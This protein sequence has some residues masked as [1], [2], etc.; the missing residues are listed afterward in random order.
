MPVVTVDTPVEAVQEYVGINRRLCFA[1]GASHFNGARQWLSN[2]FRA[3]RELVPDLEAHGLAY[4]R[5]PE[6]FECRLASVDSSSHVAGGR[7]GL[8]WQF[9]K[10]RGIINHGKWTD[11]RRRPWGELA[12]EVRQLLI[13]SGLTHEVLCD[14]GAMRSGWTAFTWFSTAQAAAALAH[15]ARKHGTRVFQAMTHAGQVAIM[16]IVV[17]HSRSDGQGFD[18]EGARADWRRAQRQ[19]REA[20]VDH[21]ADYIVSLQRER[22]S[23]G[24]RRHARSA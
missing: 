1:G 21:V 13:R 2:R 3:A 10:T 4:V 20:F 11:L 19:R 23:K 16:A 5:W 8:L 22:G 9:H 24:G 12:P 7:Y 17:R 15:Y 18:F 14:D 6:M